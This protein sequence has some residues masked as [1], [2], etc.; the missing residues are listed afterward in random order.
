MKLSALHNLYPSI[1][2]AV[3]GG[4]P[5]LR[6]DIK[7]IPRNSILIAVNYHAHEIGLHPH[8]MV[9]LDDPRTRPQMM[10]AI[11]TCDVIKVC[12]ETEPF[13]DVEMDTTYWRG[14][15]S[16]TTAAWLGLHLGCNPVYLCGMD[17]YQGAVKYC[18]DNWTPDQVP[19]LGTDDLMRPWV[20]ECRHCVPHPERLIAVSGPLQRLFP[21]KIGIL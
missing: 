10:H 13:G 1:P 9:Y 20:E 19:T 2:A 3:L 7:Q 12:P 5:S 18:H 17:L 15:N 14:N 6:E 8:F 16:A 21:P 4:G 11:Q